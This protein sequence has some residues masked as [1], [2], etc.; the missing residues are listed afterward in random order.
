MI[1]YF[2]YSSYKKKKENTDF[3]G[4]REEKKLVSIEGWRAKRN[5][6][7]SARFSSIVARDTNLERFK[8]THIYISYTRKI[9][10]CK[11][12]DLI[13]ESNGYGITRVQSCCIVLQRLVIEGEP[14]H[15]GHHRVLLGSACRAETVTLALTIR[16]YRCVR[17]NFPLGVV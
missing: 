3:E 10:G 2:V 8:N 11:A 17:S 15:A 4:K 12:K 7:S 13:A 14:C 1:R 5:D 9:N 16:I 6:N